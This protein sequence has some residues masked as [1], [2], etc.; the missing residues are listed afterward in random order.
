MNGSGGLTLPPRQMIPKTPD[1]GRYAT[2]YMHA[3]NRSTARPEVAMTPYPPNHPAADLELDEPVM[4]QNMST[5]QRARS[6]V[7]LHPRAHVSL[8]HYFTDTGM[9]NKPYHNLWHGVTIAPKKEQRLVETH[10]QAMLDKA[11][12]LHKQAPRK[13]IYDSIPG[14]A[15]FVASKDSGNVIGSTYAKSLKT[16]AQMTMTTRANNPWIRSLS[17]PDLR[18]TAPPAP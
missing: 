2:S 5:F 18:R 8:E 14:Y 3:T 10:Y 7:D 1:R 16:A 4:E 12:I 6:E 11:K 13:Y 9:A 17:S 15:G